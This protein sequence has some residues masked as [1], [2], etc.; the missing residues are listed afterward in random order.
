MTSKKKIGIAAVAVALVGVAAMAHAGRDHDRHERG[1]GH[2]GFGGMERLSD[3]LDLN[4]E[5]REQTRAIVNSIREFHRGHRESARMEIAVIFTQDALSSD[6]AQNLLN[7]RQRHREEGRA[8]M[9]AKLAEFHG[10]LTP[11][12]REQAVALLEKRGGFLQGFGRD[13]DHR[14]KKRGRKHW[15]WDDHHHD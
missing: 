13:N 8:F 7:L 15:D 4:D 9:G 1:F 14:G 6:E 5:Q 10:I 3:A 11:A 12:Q 2:F